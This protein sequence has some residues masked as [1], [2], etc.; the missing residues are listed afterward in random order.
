M[1]LENKSKM[2]F[3]LVELL[4]AL[5]VFA[6]LAAGVFAVATNSYRS[7]YG[8]GDRQVITEYAQE[9]IEATKFI[10]YN[11]WLGL[12]N[13][14]SGNHG[15]SK[16]NGLWT[17]SGTS[18]TLGNLTRVITV[19]NVQRSVT[20]G[21]IV[22]SGG[23]DDPQTKKIAV[24][25]SGTGIDDYVLED[26]VMDW[27]A[28]VWEQTDW[29][30]VGNR[31]FWGNTNMASSSYYLIVTSTVGQ[32]KTPGGAFDIASYLYSSIYDL[33]STD[34]EL[35][36]VT[37]EE[38]IRPSSVCYLTVILEGDDDTNFS[39]EDYVSQVFN[40]S[41]NRDSR[42]IYS[43]STSTALNGKRYLRYKV[44]MMDCGPGVVGGEEEVTLFSFKLN[45][46]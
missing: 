34:R 27:N 4:I 3:S 11:S 41:T 18:D 25:I 1:L 15:L 43:S 7:F 5:G 32:L 14:V 33:G 12:T 9:G 17:F 29:S 20:T 39:G 19:A 40:D 24:T 44:N 45:Y 10:G 28:K 31:E 42:Y 36:S 37:I 6:I 38:F 13:A 46:R 21:A 16:T 23:I 8:V 2:G 26:Y 30:G 22:T 35:R